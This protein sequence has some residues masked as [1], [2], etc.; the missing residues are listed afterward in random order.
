VIFKFLRDSDAP[1]PPLA[2]RLVGLAVG[3]LLLSGAVYVALG[4]IEAVV[5]ML[6]P[7]LAV[8]VIYGVMF[9]RGRR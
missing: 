7:F 2:G 8:A 9:G 6:V 3:V 5:T 4:V 1:R